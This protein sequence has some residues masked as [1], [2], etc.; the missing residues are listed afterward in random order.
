MFLDALTSLPR[1]SDCL[2]AQVVCCQWPGRPEVFVSLLQ[3]V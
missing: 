1:L 3:G 2:S